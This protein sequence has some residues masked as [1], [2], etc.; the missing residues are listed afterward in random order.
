MKN[1][2]ELWGTRFVYYINELQKYLKYIISGHIAIVIVFA[3]GAAG[4][5]YSEW[6]KEVSPDFPAALLAAIII[7]AALT[8]SSPV[9]LLKPADTVYFLPLETKLHQYFKQSL[10]WSNYI[11]NFLYQLFCI[12]LRFATIYRQQ[13]LA[14]K[15]NLF[16]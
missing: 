13:K 9:T 3:I 6:L 16:G 11:H 7:A 4:Y 12:L 2:R 14:R 5:T 10:R 8:F 1:L 15:R